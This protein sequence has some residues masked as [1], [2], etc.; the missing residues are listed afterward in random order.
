ML[1][2]NDTMLSEAAAAQGLHVCKAHT[3]NSIFEVRVDLLT[4][5]LNSANC[6]VLLK[7][8]N[9]TLLREDHCEHTAAE[10]IK[11]KLPQ[12]EVL[13]FL[14]DAAHAVITAAMQSL[15]WLVCAALT[16]QNA[17]AFAASTPCFPKKHDSAASLLALQQAVQTAPKSAARHCELGRALIATGNTIDGFDSLVSNTQSRKWILESCSMYASALAP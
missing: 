12:L 2:N 15:L 13:G 10:L 4:A 1:P 14:F 16:A 3:I 17:V 9:A 7:F 5:Y 6:V 8:S 11:C